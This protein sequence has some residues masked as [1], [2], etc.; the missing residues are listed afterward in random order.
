MIT[1]VLRL[2]TVMV[3]CVLL[4]DV[5]SSQLESRS[6]KRSGAKYCGPYLADIFH[7]VCGGKYNVLIEKKS[8]G[9]L[10]PSEFMR[11]DPDGEDSFWMQNVA[12]EGLGFPFRPK[13]IATALVPGSFRRVARGAYDECCRKSCTYHEIRTY[14]APTPST[15]APQ[16]EG[17]WGE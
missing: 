12:L 2:V 9:D 6:E 5:S 1:I 8:S 4:L 16:S 17:Q 7:L 15:P 10:M 13:S 11:P 3:L 14:C